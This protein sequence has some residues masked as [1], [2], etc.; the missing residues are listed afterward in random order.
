[1]VPTGRLPLAQGR[2]TFIRRV[3]LTGT[4][5]VLSQSFRVGKRHRGLYL[6]LVL[7]TGRG[8][9]TAYLDGRVS[10]RW[11]YKLLNDY[12]TLDHAA[13]GGSHGRWTQRCAVGPCRLALLNDRLY[14]D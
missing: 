10:K 12:P 14:W 13:T 11:P 7:D 6:R 4:V 9:L 8:R 1:M 5:T 3:S 2:V